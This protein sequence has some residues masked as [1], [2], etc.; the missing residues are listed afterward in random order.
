V[1]ATV[2]YDAC[3]LH[4]PSLRDLLIR[5]SVAGLVSAR[6]SPTALDEVFASIRSRRP[7]LA[8]DRLLRTRRLMC[9]A[10]PTAS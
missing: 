7:D 4:P 1:P 5:L 10:A 2:V 9:E 6:W 3:V 8:D